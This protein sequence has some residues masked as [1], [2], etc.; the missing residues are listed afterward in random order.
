MNS[1]SFAIR[2]FRRYMP[3]VNSAHR[4][5]DPLL[6]SVILCLVIL[7]NGGRWTA[8]DTIAVILIPLLVIAVFGLFDL[9]RSWRGASLLS[10][11][12]R[13][14]LAWFAV[15]CLLIPLGHI[16]LIP[17]RLLNEIFFPFSLLVPLALIVE[18]FGTRLILRHFRSRGINSRTVVIAGAGNLGRDLSRLIRQQAGYGLKVVGF[19][20]DQFTNGLT[21]VDGLPVL[22]T[23]EDLP[24]YVRENRIDYLYLALPF[25]AEQRMLWLVGELRDA[26]AA[27]FLVPD[28]FIFQIFHSRYVDL[29]GIP[30]FSMSD[31]PFTGFEGLTKRIQDIVFSSLILLFV[32]PL[33]LVI[34]VLV[35][36]TSK[37]PVFFIQKRY[38]LNGEGIRVFK[39]RTMSVLEDGDDVRQAQ[40]SDPRVTPLGKF[41]RRTSLDELPQFINVLQG[42]M[43]IVG[44]RP[45]AVA[46]NEYYRS[47]I[48]GYMRRHNVKPGITGWA[49]VNGWRGETETIEKMEKRVEY[50]LHYI[51]NW[52]IWL[53]MKIIWMTLYRGFTGH[54]AY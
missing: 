18:R 14:I 21:T 34:A 11:A 46:H 23:L 29:G 15:I 52:S 53:D 22:G 39:F 35:K 48:S 1:D 24:H 5:L 51:R 16:V 26:H 8:Y 45:H 44:P 54:N 41:L 33:L 19:F 36:L 30:V 50:D 4:V 32:S 27:V 42:T 13:I 3:L 31:N 49:Q 6:S 25:R 9:Y 40:A 17:E 2:L 37:G 43:S 47:K 7:L 10:E 38:G 12:R 20:D 28:I